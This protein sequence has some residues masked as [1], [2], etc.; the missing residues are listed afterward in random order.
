MGRRGYMS[1]RK[2]LAKAA[3][4]LGSHDAA[5]RLITEALINGSMRA[6]GRPPSEPAPRLAGKLSNIGQAKLGPPK[7]IEEISFEFWEPVTAGDVERWD[8]FAGYFCSLDTES[9]FPA[10]GEVSF[11]E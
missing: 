3:R 11:K 2:S 1:S 7:P 8:W 6:E 9:G 5:R 10:Y 4:E